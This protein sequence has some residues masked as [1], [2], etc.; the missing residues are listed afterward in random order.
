MV[1]E[2]WLTPQKDCKTRVIGSMQANYIHETTGST[3]KM[4]FSDIWGPYMVTF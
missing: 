1:V 2:T 4:H 3:P